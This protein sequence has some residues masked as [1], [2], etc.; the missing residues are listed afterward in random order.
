VI[1]LFTDFGHDGLY[2][3]QLHAVIGATLPDTKV[4]DL[5]HSIPPHDIRAAAYLLPAYTRYLPP[6]SI[7]VCVV[8][9]GVGS[10]RP[11]AACMADNR[12][13]IGPDNGLFDVL[14]QHALG[15]RKYHY[16]W[17]GEVSNTFHARDIYVPAACL[18]AESAATDDLLV[19][20][21]ETA[22][23]SFSADLYEVVY[24]DHFGNA[25]TGC[26]SSNLSDGAKIKING[27]RLHRARIFSDVELGA[28]FWYE[29]ANGLVEIAAN[30]GSAR[31]RLGLELGDSFSF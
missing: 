17:P 23:L 6:A 14:E 19:K 5:C 18:F 4:V 30:Q 16:Q 20:P 2:V 9:P 7:T 28:C 21:V 13:Y 3:G 31:E 10:E 12:W 1:A 29:N 15:F 8:D 25:I 26:R 24:F 27:Q 11:H 22:K